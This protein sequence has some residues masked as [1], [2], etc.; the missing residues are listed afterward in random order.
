MAR[1]DPHIT[2]FNHP[3]QKWMEAVLSLRTEFG[4][5]GPPEAFTEFITRRLEDETMLLLIAWA[6]ETPAGYGLAFDVAE[7]PFMPEWTRAGYITQFL[8][9][10]QYRRQGVGQ[11]LMDTIDD[12][13][14][15]RG[16]QKVMLNVDI[17]NETGIQFWKRWGFEPYAMRMRRIQ[18]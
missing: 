14:R 6:N 1:V 17:A 4:H 11:M 16:L 2:R 13:F 5:I 18:V 8:V 12:W 15:S 10:R 7:H 3:D 9:S